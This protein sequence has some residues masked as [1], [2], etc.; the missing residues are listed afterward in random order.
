MSENEKLPPRHSDRGEKGPRAEP[1][2]AEPSIPE[3]PPQAPKEP[4]RLETSRTS[5]PPEGAA[6]VLITPAEPQR[7]ARASR[8]RPALVI[9]GSVAAVL[10]L[11]GVVYIAAGRLEKRVAPPEAAPPA[12]GNGDRSR[13][14]RRAPERAATPNR[15]QRVPSPTS[16]E[17]VRE[18][19]PHTPDTAPRRPQGALSPPS[20]P[21]PTSVRARVAEALA[22]GDFDQAVKRLDR[23]ARTGSTGDRTWARQ[24]LEQIDL[25]S[26]NHEAQKLLEG[27]TA[28]QLEQIA[29]GEVEPHVRGVFSDPALERRFC[30]TL[31]ANARLLLQRRDTRKADKSATVLVPGAVEA[32]PAGSPTDA[33]S[34][35]K[36]PSAPSAPAQ[37]KPTSPGATASLEK[38]GLEKR[39]DY[40]MLASD[41]ELKEHLERLERAERAYRE[42]DAAFRE[43]AHA[44][45]RL[46]AQ[47]SAIGG[48]RRQY[49]ELLVR[50]MNARTAFTLAYLQ[51]AAEADRLEDRYRKLAADPNVQT[52]LDQ[53]DPASNQL[54]PTPVF[55]KNRARID[56]HRSELLTDQTVGFYG[57][58]RDDDV[59]HVSVILCDRTAA[60]FAYRPRASYNLIPE[61]VLGQA[62][63]ELPP[64]RNVELKIGGVRFR[65][66][67]VIVP[68][69]RIGKFVSRNVEAYML[70]ARIGRL[71]FLSASAFPDVRI[72]VPPGQDVARL[73][74]KASP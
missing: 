36:K 10:A 59:F 39:G 74:R 23:V 72:E 7:R 46:G 47:P 61:A 22:C 58:G 3:P 30:Q 2:P 50:Y 45:R 28:G 31:R 16:P 62:D 63:I 73:V 38:H 26:S 70:P 51:G 71:G 55:R 69:L 68:S 41:D 12:V 54:G 42:A 24:L 53:R 66:A 5:K 20:A 67:R 27:F 25:A 40:W 35:G 56:K 6:A 60:W 34:G 9:A 33:G 65:T 19:E 4:P 52:A 57:E 11:A 64:D 49:R 15:P 13:L 18:E 1:P 48:A 44:L 29:R 14:H 8:G 37:P 43:A 17:A 21:G 32:R